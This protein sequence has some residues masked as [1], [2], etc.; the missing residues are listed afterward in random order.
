MPNALL[1]LSQNQRLFERYDVR[2]ETKTDNRVILD[3]TSGRLTT[4]PLAESGLASVTL[5]PRRD[6]G[7]CFA[8]TVSVETLEQVVNQ[9]GKRFHDADYSEKRFERILKNLLGMTYALNV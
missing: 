6:P 5:I 7:I 3:A 1:H 2:C 4:E 9:L 8:K